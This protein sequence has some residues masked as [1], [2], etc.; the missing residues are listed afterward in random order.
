MKVAVTA[1]GQDMTSEIDPRFGRARFLIEVDT[2]TG[3]FA[4]H[5]N[6]QNINAVQGAGIQAAQNVIELGVAAVLTGNVG[7]KAFSTLE[8]GNVKVH[9]GA[10]GTVESVV[11]QFR[12]GQLECTAKPTVKGHWA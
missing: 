8:A 1:Q 9:T 11:E 2:D 3:A 6:A 10:T 7:P 4:A 5:D 12:A